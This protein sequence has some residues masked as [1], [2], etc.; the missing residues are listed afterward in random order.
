MREIKNAEVEISW[1]FHLKIVNS[2]PLTASQVLHCYEK[3]FH[4]LKN[5]FLK[6]T[7][8]PFINQKFKLLCH[9]GVYIK[10]YVY[11]IHTE[12]DIL[13]HRESIIR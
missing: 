4:R 13:S 10:Q 9:F 5:H 6:S 1:H 8:H 11:M 2:N 3:L 12:R 7:S